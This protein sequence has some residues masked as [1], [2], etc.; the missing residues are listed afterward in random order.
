M[1]KARKSDDLENKP[2]TVASDTFR[3]QD[4]MQ[5]MYSTRQL[6]T[7]GWGCASRQMEGYRFGV[8]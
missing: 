8:T 6:G 2:M 4:S 5:V 7:P 1:G 3:C